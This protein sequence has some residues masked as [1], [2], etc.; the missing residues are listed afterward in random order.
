MRSLALQ[1]KLRLGLFE[2]LVLSEMC[3]MDLTQR[4]DRRLEKTA[5]GDSQFVI[6]RNTV[7]VIKMRRTDWVGHVMS[8]GEMRNS[9]KV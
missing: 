1:E 8:M 9:L 5:E 6:S 4:S 2:N 7:M 3:Y